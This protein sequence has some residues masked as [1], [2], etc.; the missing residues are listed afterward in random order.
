MKLEGKKVLVTG[1][2]GFIGSHLTERLVELGAEVTALVQYNSFNNWGWIDTFSKEVK[3]NINIVTGDIREYDGMK[4]IIK[5]Q[6]V[7]FHL[8]ALIAIPYSYLSPMAY[9]KTNIEGTTNVLEAC[10]EYEVEKI[11]HTSTS[12]TYGTALYVPIDEKHPM[13]G[14]SPYSAS[15]IGAD[16]I[17]ESFY[18]SFNLPVV[19]IRPFNTYGPRQSARA[20]IPTIISQILAEKTEIKLGGL[21][22]TRDFNYV[23]DT[24]E[25]F[26]KVV[27]SNKTI[28]QVINA[29]SNY[30][31]SI[32]DTVR[33]II[34]IIGKDVKILCDEERIRPEKSEVNRL[35]AD[36]RKIKELTSW[37]PRYS[38]DDG[39]KETIEWI[40]NNMK[41][42]KTDIYNV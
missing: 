21:S 7:V 40:R 2:E 10:R 5:G 26:I 15:K 3:D 36:N 37:N 31:I 42:F 1:S 8:A 24:V 41:H 17:A 22:P 30:E 19:T 33:K 9:V 28:G 4:R 20:V 16:K 38:L 14:Q 39:L 34:N 35:W 23:K 6:D 32:G 29:G 11:V 27:E 12:E 18:R 13:H 25:A